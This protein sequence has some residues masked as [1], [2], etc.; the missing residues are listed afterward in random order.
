[1]K[2]LIV[3]AS[4]LASSAAGAS[5]A[6]LGA[7]PRMSPMIA[8]TYDWSGFYWGGNG[9]WG[10]SRNC[11]DIVTSAGTLVTAEGCHNATGGVAGGQ[12]GFRMQSYGWVFGVEAQGDWAGLRGS[13]VSNAFFL[14]PGDITNRSRLDAFGLFTGQVGYAWGSTLLYVKG[15]AAVT[16]ARYNDILT[17]TG[18]VAA[19]ASDTRAGG[20]V[21]AGLEYGFIPGWSVAVE[22]DHLFMGSR[23]LSL[24]SL[25]IIPGLP[26]G[27]VPVVTDRIRQDVDLVTVRVNY[28]FGGP[29]I[30]KY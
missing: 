21:G 14:V 15:G 27:G 4:I 28:T 16:A 24:S 3:A 18:L 22:Y 13:K 12:L 17:A 19:T 26:P 1:M 8:A 9:G 25:G 7:Q 30:A 10:S 23:N 2:K 29:A 20:T 11:W 5:A 6:D